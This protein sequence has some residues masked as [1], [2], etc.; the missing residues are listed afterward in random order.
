[1]LLAGQLYVW[2]D[3]DIG[4]GCVAP[5]THMHIIRMSGAA[6]DAPPS[7]TQ[8]TAPPPAYGMQ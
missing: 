7:Y 1:M 2:G 8:A 6:Q 3:C 4:Q 5:P